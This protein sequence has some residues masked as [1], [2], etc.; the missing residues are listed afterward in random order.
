M[1][2]ST[3]AKRHRGSVVLAILA[4]FVV[5]AGYLL[6][7][8]LNE[9]FVQRDKISDDALNKAKEALIGFAATYRDSPA[10]AGSPVF[11]YLPC[12]ATDGGG[13][14]GTCGA[15]NVTLVRPLPWNTIGMPPLRDSSGECLWYAVSGT[16][17][18]SPTTAAMNW[19]TVG[20]L[21]IND[22]AG[23]VL[24][25]GAAAAIIAPR[26]K[27]GAQNRTPLGVTQ[28][29][30]NITVAAYLEGA[31]VSPV[32]LAIS[33]LTQSTVNSINL[34]TNNDRL[35]WVTPAE[36]FNRIKQRSDFKTDIDTMMTNLVT[37]LNNRSV[38]NLPVPNG[39]KGIGSNLETPTVCP[40]PTS[41]TL[42]GNVYA[43]WK[44]NLLYA[45]PGTPIT[46]NG[47]NCNAVLIFGG[48]RTGAQVRATAAERDL[49]SNYLEG[50]NL[51]SFPAGA[52]YTGLA[53]YDKANS[54]SDIVRCVT[55]NGAGPGGTQ[56][57]FAADFNNFVTAG[58]GVT[59][60]SGTQT[61]TVAP[62]AGTR[63]GCFWYPTAM[64]LNGKKLRAYYTYTFTNA[65][66]RALGGGGP[67]HGN[68]FSLSFLRGDL[69]APGNCGAQNDMGSLDASDALGNISLFVETDVHRD[70]ADNDPVENH[71]AI[72]ANGNFNHP[73][74]TVT[75]ACNG[76]TRGCSHSP[77]NKFEESPAP[78]PHNQRVE[79]HTGY[80]DAACTTP[81][82]G[83]YA[84]I[85][86][87]VDC[88]GCT[89]TSVDFAPTPTIV[90]CTLLDPALNS[91]YFGFTGG[92]RTGGAAQGVIIQNLDL[93]TQ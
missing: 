27:F 17:K 55:G 39:S 89:D 57:T 33:T 48:E 74:G 78:L 28:C 82:G 56:V 26:A 59:T 43:N 23:N 49:A 83:N 88:A 45:R 86:A 32:A 47:A 1:Q 5:V 62:S 72:M 90:R 67:D 8:G 79:I 24:A 65:D 10:H 80:T 9:S 7:K 91:F 19:D 76:T 30:N 63:G 77:A 41:G 12:P 14:A 84:L 36:I 16:F 93:R 34:N 37:C 6:V 2:T 54:S 3:F 35:I 66:T 69:G 52:T 31:G 51:A 61:V 53:A 29:R 21:N 64:P 44:D 11:G 60:N 15:L 18:D 40:P 75:T 20:Q 70:V 92:F 25:T 68:G 42:Q 4:M 38:A 13:I 73:A 50:T 85:K 71:T 87:W 58:T 22:A 46:V 81:G